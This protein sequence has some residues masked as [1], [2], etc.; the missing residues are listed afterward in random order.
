[1][2]KNSSG[3]RRR[4]D[5]AS[6]VKI[7]LEALRETMPL[8]EL[9]SKHGVHP[10]QIT[11]WKAK[12]LE[13]A[14]EIFSGKTSEREELEQSRRTIEQLT[15]QIGE[16]AIDNNFLKKNLKKLNLL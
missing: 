9:A 13:K 15:H 7:V 3:V 1:M 5:D 6:K 8:S 2:P 12:F 14:P 10:N 4:F 16:L 11:R